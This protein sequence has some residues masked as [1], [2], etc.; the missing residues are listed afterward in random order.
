MLIQLRYFLKLTQTCWLL[1][2]NLMSFS[3]KDVKNGYFGNVNE[4]IE[5]ACK[6]LGSMDAFKD[7]YN[8]I[9]LSQGGQFL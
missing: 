7:G 1:V 4:Q 2:N 9:G 5:T 3:L 6:K 8:A